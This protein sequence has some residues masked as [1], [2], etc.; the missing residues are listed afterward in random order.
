MSECSFCKELDFEANI[1]QRFER[2][3]HEIEILVAI[4]VKSSPLEYQDLVSS[5]IGEAHKLN[6]CPECGKPIRI[7][8]LY[9]NGQPKGGSDA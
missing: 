6:F 4:C 3:G 2:P 7:P 9:Q 8:T 1:I 5:C